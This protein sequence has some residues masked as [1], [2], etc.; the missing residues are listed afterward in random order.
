MSKK[1]KEKGWKHQ[2]CQRTSLEEIRKV[3]RGFS[4]KGHGPWDD[5]G[6]MMSKGDN[7]RGRGVCHKYVGKFTSAKEAL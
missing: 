4:S 2:G 3:L 1:V 7:L 5:V 6:S